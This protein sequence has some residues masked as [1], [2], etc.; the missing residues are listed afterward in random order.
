MSTKL[1]QLRLFGSISIL[2]S[3]S[4]AAAILG[5]GPDAPIL[6]T[7]LLPMAWTAPVTGAGSAAGVMAATEFISAVDG[8]LGLNLA[9]LVRLL[10]GSSQHLDLA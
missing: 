1:M 2:T 6:A 4:R 3:L 10:A 7:E 8:V 5:V 9:G